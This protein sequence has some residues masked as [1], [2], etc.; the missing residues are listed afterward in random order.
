M[1]TVRPS[2]RHLKT[3]SSPGEQT[4]ANQAQDIN[5][6]VTEEYINTQKKLKAPKKKTKK[7]KA[8]LQKVSCTEVRTLPGKEWDPDT[9][10]EDIWVYGPEKPELPNSPAP[11]IPTSRAA[12]PCPE[13]MS[14]PQRGRC[15]SRYFSS[16]LSAHTSS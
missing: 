9:W 1:N 8:Q 16:S 14:K 2:P 5:V 4:A 7:L 12:S 6:K 3:P 11:S 13:A 10:N 15:L